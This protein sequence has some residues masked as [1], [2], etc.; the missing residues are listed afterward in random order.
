[1]ANEPGTWFVEAGKNPDDFGY[2]NQGGLSRK[3]R[4]VTVR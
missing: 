1:M 3:V 2:V 4:L